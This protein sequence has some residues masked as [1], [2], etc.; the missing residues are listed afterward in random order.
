MPD[1]LCR[2]GLPHRLTIEFDDQ[3]RIYISGGKHKPG[4]FAQACPYCVS[5]F[6]VIYD[7]DGR[8]IQR[9]TA[10]PEPPEPQAPPEPVNP[11]TYVIPCNSCG[12]AVTGPL[13]RPVAV[14]GW[15]DC[16]QCLANRPVP[17]EQ[18]HPYWEAS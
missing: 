5:V 14:N 11:R 4:W 15:V 10:T 8:V 6:P 2:D 9:P 1:D 17:P 7:E 18:L 12:K 13:E 3:A 16:P